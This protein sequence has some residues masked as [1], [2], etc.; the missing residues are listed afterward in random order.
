MPAAPFCRGVRDQTWLRA[1]CGLTPLGAQL[2][3]AAARVP[4]VLATSA[5]RGNIDFVLDGLRLRPRFTDVVTAA[6]V[7]RGKPDPE[8]YLLAAQRVG[9][10]PARSIVVEDSLAGVASGLAAGCRVVG[11]TTTHAAEELVG[12]A[13]TAPDFRDIGL[14]SLG[15]LF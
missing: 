15:A 10:A 11:L 12:C 9:A 5:P 13:L 7:Q 4:V 2:E 14:A 6:D 1:G 8:I 3:T